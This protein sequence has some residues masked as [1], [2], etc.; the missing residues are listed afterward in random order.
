F[1]ASPAN[2][3]Q[4]ALVIKS[5]ALSGQRQR[6]A[7]QHVVAELGGALGRPA[8]GL[9]EMRHQR[10][11]V[12]DRGAL[13]GVDAGAEDQ[14]VRGVAEALLL[15]GQQLGGAEFVDRADDAGPAAP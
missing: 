7:A 3:R 13:V 15:A 8:A 11:D 4:L 6:A 14:R 2:P 9:G 5:R 10:L 1:E 12:G